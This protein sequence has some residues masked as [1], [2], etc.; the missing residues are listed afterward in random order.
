MKKYSK[1]FT[2]VNFI[3][4]S[5]VLMAY[6]IIRIK[7]VFLRDFPK[8]DE[9]S[10][11]KVFKIYLNEGY[12]SA[13]VH[14]NSTP[15]NVISGFFNK[16]I[17]NPVLSLR[18][19]SLFFGVLSI[20]LLYQFKKKHFKMPLNYGF[21]GILTALNTIIVMS[22]IWEGVNDIILTF[23]TLLFFIVFYEWKNKSE[24]LKYFIFFGI[25]LGLMLS[26]RKMSILFFPSMA[27]VILFTT[28]IKKIRFTDILKNGSISFA[29]MIIVLLLLSFPSIHENKTL[30]FHE[31]EPP[32][33]TISWTQLQYLT[34]IAIENNSVDFGQHVTVE[35][36]EKYILENGINSLPNTFLDSIFFN[37]KRTFK[38]FFIDFFWNS[39]PFS[40]LLGIFFIFAILLFI[41]AVYKKKINLMSIEN[42]TIFVFSACYVVI[43]SFVVIGYVETRWFSNILIPL[44]IVLT[45][46]LYR[47]KLN[48]K[49]SYK[50]D[51]LILNIQLGSIIIMNLPYIYKN[52]NLFY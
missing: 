34:T 23:L 44:S 46:Y 9:K 12:Y 52:I 43:L 41:Y 38:E 27:I 51:F 13:N 26:V 30:S 8:G 22:V 11:L 20:I 45:Y 19:T 24:N 28:I 15:F 17:Q 47:F 7:K 4:V 6:S 1:I 5:V 40:R 35:E 32:S 48:K 31:K 39:K 25:I 3:I 37:L 49:Y 18:C 42:N 14:G 36:T 21:V 2:I 33:E 10:Y 50:Y 29:V 16:I